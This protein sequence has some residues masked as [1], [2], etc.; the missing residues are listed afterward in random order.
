MLG[1]VYMNQYANDWVPTSMWLM[2]G[3]G[4]RR[5]LTDPRAVV[6]DHATVRKG[7]PR[8][9]CGALLSAPFSTRYNATGANALEA[10]V[11]SVLSDFNGL[12]CIRF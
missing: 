3:G 11:C 7:A 8:A 1:S 2:A 6:H 4:C 12:L 5:G 9:V 10:L